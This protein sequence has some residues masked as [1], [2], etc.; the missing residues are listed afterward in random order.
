VSLPLPLTSL[1]GRE[2]DSI[3]S[4]QKDLDSVRLNP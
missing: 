3:D 1:L 4:L 2:R